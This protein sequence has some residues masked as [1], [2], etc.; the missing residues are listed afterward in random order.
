M[1][2]RMTNFRQQP[3]AF[4][5]ST[6]FR[7]DLPRGSR[8][9]AA[10]GRTSMRCSLRHGVPTELAA[11][12]HVESSYNPAARS[13]VGASGIWQFTRSTGRRFMRVDHVLDERNDPFR[14]TEAAAKLLAYNYSIAG[15]WPM[16]IT[17]YNHGLAGAR[18]AMRRHGDTAYTD[19][20]RRYNG[21]AFGFASR[22]FYVAFFSGERN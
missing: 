21:R 19:I 2:S 8:G 6:A 1:T 9:R 18:R 11:L 3:G 22:N 15:N 10:G 5:S 17:A 13:H 16:A 12:P 14:A 4:A 7:T 20:L